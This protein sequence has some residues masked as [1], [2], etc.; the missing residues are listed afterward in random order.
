MTDRLARQSTCSGS[1]T[2]WGV[3]FRFLSGTESQ[4]V[5]LSRLDKMCYRW[6][7]M[8][9]LPSSLLRRGLARRVGVAHRGHCVVGCMPGVAGHVGGSYG[10]AG[11]PSRGPSRRITR[12]PSRSVRGERGLTGL[13]YGHLPTHP[14][15]R[16]FDCLA[17][18]RISRVP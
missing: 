14:G 13:T 4:G 1:A 10:L 6:R 11:R 2:H 5:L 7:Q 17:R 8:S 9:L 18:T 12:L 16:R 3:R 15:T